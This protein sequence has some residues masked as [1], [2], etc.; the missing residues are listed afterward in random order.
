MIVNTCNICSRVGPT[1]L[2]HVAIL[3]QSGTGRRMGGDVPW[4]SVAVRGFVQAET[5]KLLRRFALPSELHVLGILDDLHLALATKD[6]R[7][8]P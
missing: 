6:W 1:R 3:Q 5:R 4:L 2:G 7:G 8:R